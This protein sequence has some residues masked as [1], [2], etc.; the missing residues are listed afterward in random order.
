MNAAPLSAGRVASH[1]RAAMTI[2]RVFVEGL[3]GAG[4]P[5]DGARLPYQVLGANHSAS[6]SLSLA[7]ATQHAASL[8]KLLALLGSRSPQP[9]YAPNEDTRLGEASRVRA[10]GGN[11]G[12][13]RQERWETYL[14]QGLIYVGNSD[15]SDRELRRNWQPYD[16]WRAL[17]PNMKE[18][19]AGAM[20]ETCNW[21]LSGAL[22][23][24]ASR[25]M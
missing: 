8:C 2:T 1:D 21:L 16:G 6:Q 23:M 19:F 5:A 12:C 15:Q 22:T 3:L 14:T 10:H 20:S 9:T 4:R 11:S 13:T 7:S 24:R 18:H 17:S 25:R